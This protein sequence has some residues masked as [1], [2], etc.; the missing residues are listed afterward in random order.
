MDASG[1]E[2]AWGLC[3]TMPADHVLDDVPGLEARTVRLRE[4]IDDQ[5]EPDGFLPEALDRGDESFWYTDSMLAPMT[6]AVEIV[7]NDLDLGLQPEVPPSGGTPRQALDTLL[8]GFLNPGGWPGPPQVLVPGV[9]DDWGQNLLFALGQ[10]YAEP[11]DLAAADMP[12]ARRNGAWKEADVPVPAAGTAVP[13]A[14]TGGLGALAIGFASG[15]A[16]LLTRR[17]RRAPHRG[18]FAA[19]AASSDG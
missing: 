17:P 15:A 16:G 18:R 19:C 7:R 3:A 1:N 11:A 8:D 4:I 2:G 9:P 13:A 14:G 10:V 12:L 5:I 6:H